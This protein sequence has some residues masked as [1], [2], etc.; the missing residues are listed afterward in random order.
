MKHAI[1]FVLF[2]LIAGSL[3]AQTQ[4]LTVQQ[5]TSASDLVVEG[6]VIECQS[7][8]NEDHTQILTSNL[9]EV[10]KVLKGDLVGDRFEVIT[11]GGKVDDRFSIVSHQ[12]TFKTGMEGVFFCKS[13][14][15]LPTLKK[16]ANKP[17]VMAVAETGFIQYYFNKFNPPAADKSGSYQ[18]VQ[19]EILNEVVLSS[20][21]PVRKIKPNTLEAKVQKA[22]SVTLENEAE[23]LV[24]PSIF[25][26][27]ENVS[28]SNGYQNIVFDVYARCSENGVKFGKANIVIDYSSEVFGENAVT[29]ENIEVSKGTIIQNSAYT[30]TTSDATSEKVLIDVTS[31]FLSPSNAYSLTTVGEQF[32]HVELEIENLLALANIGFDQF[33]MSG[34]CWYYD[35]EAGRYLL[36]ERVEVENPIDGTS[37]PNNFV[38]INYEFDNVSVTESGGNK[39]LEF[40]INGYSNVS[41]TRLAVSSIFIGYNPDAFGSNPVSSGNFSHTI[42]PDLQAL[43]YDSFQDHLNGH[44]RVYTYQNSPDSLDYLKLPT[45]PIQIVHCKIKIL[46]C[47]ENAGINFGKE[48]MNTFPQYYFGGLPIPLIEY[49]SYG[50]EGLVSFYDQFLCKEKAPIITKISPKDLRAGIFE[51]LTVKGQ[52]L[53]LSDTLSGKFYFRDSERPDTTIYDYAYDEDVIIWND[54]LIEIYVPSDLVNSIGSA[55][56]GKVIV[57]NALGNL[58]ISDE[59]ISIQYSLTNFRDTTF[60]AHRIFF[61]NANGSGG[62]SWRMD[63]DLISYNPDDCINRAIDEWACISS[64]NWPL[65]STGVCCPDQAIL[66]GNS[67]IILGDSLFLPSVGTSALAYTVLSGHAKPCDNGMSLLLYYVDDIDIVFNKYKVYQFD[68]DLSAGGDTLDFFDILLHELGHAHMLEHSVDDG[69]AIYTYS[70]GAFPNGND[71]AGIKESIRYSLLWEED[72]DCPLKHDT[73]SCKTSSVLDVQFSN[74]DF[75]VFP[76][77]FSEKIV[78]ESSKDINDETCIFIFDVTGKLAFSKTYAQVSALSPIELSGKNLPPGFYVLQIRRKDEAIS[79]KLLKQ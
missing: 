22:F 4:K 63:D 77:P 19:K 40:D 60:E 49:D 28:F 18:N 64:I 71:I 34:N 54:T 61:I 8:W 73:V 47:D 55:A 68:C 6:K 53:R 30:L 35:A 16:S 24:G 9:V 20:R 12:T 59:E 42:S 25:F 52:N 23:F 48:L 3:T 46:D 13:S 14:E 1:S 43:G 39:F 66:D 74:S 58:A 17:C 15:K 50:E 27:F 56:S 36:F 57:E 62:Y 41:W 5:R 79:F 44:I 31:S 72:G 7:F 33:Q 67:T 70:F 75:K 37:D 10:F 69:S 32:C 26:T 78:I 76:V 29:N 38:L 11:R 65:S 51:V 21:E 2:C 45:T